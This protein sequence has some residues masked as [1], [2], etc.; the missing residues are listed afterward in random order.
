MSFIIYSII[1]YFIGLFV[2]LNLQNK[3]NQPFGK[4]IDRWELST[5]IQ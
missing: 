1:A 2:S 4:I 5:E 3:I